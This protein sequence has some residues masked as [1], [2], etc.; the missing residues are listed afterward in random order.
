MTE[1]EIINELKQRNGNVFE[2]FI[3]QYQDMVYNTALGILQDEDDA[4][5]AT[6][7]VFI[8]VYNSVEN[9]NEQSSLKTWLYRIAVNKSI[10]HLRARE[11]KNRW[12]ISAWFGNHLGGHEPVEFN[13]P[14]VQLDKKEDAA[15]LFKTMKRLP[16]NQRTAFA[17]QK[18]EGLSVEE[19]ASAMQMN[20]TTV[21][22]LLARAKTNLKKYLI[23]QF[24]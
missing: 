18:I 8:K 12:Q 9:F 7:E 10:D 3:K 11:R 16:I 2:A 20:K 6:Q 15:K 22:S 23:D 19:I 13:H 21:E 17:L 5:D 14:G 1:H 24:Q 4:D